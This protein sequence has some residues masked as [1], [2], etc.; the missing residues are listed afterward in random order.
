MVVGLTMPNRM[1]A[2]N[3]S[4]AAV[5]WTQNLASVGT[6]YETGFATVPP[7]VSQSK[8]LVVSTVLVNADIA[9]NTITQLAFALNAQTGAIMWTQPIGTGPIPVG[10]FVSPT[11]L[12]DSNRVYLNNPLGKNVVALDLQTGASKW[13]AAVTTPEGKFS[14]GPG[15]LV[16]GKLIQPVGPSLYTLKASTGKVL[17]KFTIGGSMTY[18]HPT[19]IGKTLYVGNSWGWVSALPVRAVTGGPIRNQS[20]GKYGDQDD[21]DDKDD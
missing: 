14:W 11:P 10:G 8:K 13:L 17:K 16:E 3:L 21:E 6:T 9:S 12:L 5:V 7:A 20:K 4:T 19:V 15:V 18:N 2:I 1:V